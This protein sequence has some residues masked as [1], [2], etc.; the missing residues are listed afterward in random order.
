VTVSQFIPCRIAE[1]PERLH[2]PAAVVA[3]EENPAN[4]PSVLPSARALLPPGKLAALRTVYWRTA[5]VSLGVYFMDGGSI[6]LKKRILDAANLWSA[7][8]ANVKFF[9][10]GSSAQAQIRIAFTPG[11]GYYSYLGTDCLLVPA[12][13]QTMNLDSFNDQTSDDEVLRVACHEFGHALGY[14]HEHQ[15]KEIVALLDRAKTIDYFGRWQGWSP[16]DVEQ[17]VLTPLDDADLITLTG[18]DVVSI[19]HYPISGEC[20]ISGQAIP[21]GTRIDAVDYAL[22]GS[23]YPGSVVVSPPPPSP[24]PSPPP[25]SPPPPQP[26]VLKMGV[27]TFDPSTA[28]WRRR[29]KDGKDETFVFGLPGDQP[30]IHDINGDGADK[31]GVFRPSTGTF[32]LAVPGGVQEI[33]FGGG[34]LIPVVGNW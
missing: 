30:V 18:A 33:K 31:V 10:V 25:P 6:R 23:L 20:T 19:M 8:G 15:R 13:E 24:P 34:G 21:G 1:L 27:G 28:T 32:Y 29:G 9:E 12:N 4:V 22:A 2:M 11:W 7:R 14:P 16:E 17:Q 3:V 26:G 5:G